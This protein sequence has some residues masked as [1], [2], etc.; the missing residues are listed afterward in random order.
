MAQ[1]KSTDGI[2]RLLCVVLFVIFS[3]T[4]L[5][6]YQADVLTATQFILAHGQTH[7]N[8]TVGAILIT[9][10]LI[11][12]EIG[13]SRLCP[14]VG[15]LFAL[16]FLPSAIALTYLTS[17]T[18]YGDGNYTFGAGV[19]LY[20]LLFVVVIA[21]LFLFS[22]GLGSRSIIISR[23]PIA[24]TLWLN[25]LILSIAF[26][27]TCAFSNSDKVMHTRL[28]VEQCISDGRYDE[29]VD[30]LTDMNIPDS[31]MT[32]LT[33]YVLSRKN[34]L[35]E[36]LFTFNIIGGSESL[37]PNKEKCIGTVFFPEDSLY[38]FIGTVYRQRMNPM[39]Y[40]KYVQHH[41][42]GN[43]HA[44]DYL[45]CGYLLDR[46]LD[47]F[48]NEIMK[49]HIVS[50][51]LPQHY[52]EALTLYTHLH[53]N[54]KLIYRSNVMDADFEDYQDMERKYSNPAERKT[55]LRTTYGNTYWYYYQ[56]K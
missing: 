31:N 23:W 48:V 34:T 10:A 33:A 26:L 25:V 29:A 51:S 1:M 42:S 44:V 6:Y 20:P 50:D 2:I 36:H 52:R 16:W 49:H 38:K 53:S 47:A 43:K 30:A 4:Y 32:M 46:N 8:R 3:F 39:H 21:L 19:Y 41:K 22:Y 9:T 15:Q 5:Y 18:I 12:L 13:V 7:Y 27:F 54:P 37:L 11:L 56:Y 55:Q 28:H 45:L 24:R 17:I 35:P 40:L 14:N